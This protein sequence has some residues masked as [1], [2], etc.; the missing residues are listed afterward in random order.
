MIL[1]Y[2]FMLFLFSLL[3]YSTVKNINDYK[4]GK[5]GSIAIGSAIFTG[6]F[7]LF[8]F[9]GIVTQSLLIFYAINVEGRTV[10]KCKS[11]KFGRGVEFEYYINGK[12]YINCNTIPSNWQIKIPDGLF[13]V[14]VS[15]LNPQEGR[16]DFEAPLTTES[17]SQR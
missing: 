17:R 14:R 8:V 5:E 4:N 16:L 15:E 7:S 11:G 12:R 3:F 1:G 10:N 9:Y 6:L 13:Q 2:L